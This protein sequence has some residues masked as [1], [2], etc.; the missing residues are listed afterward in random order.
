MQ[1]QSPIRSFRKSLSRSRGTAGFSLV[2]VIMALGVMSFAMMGMLGLLSVGLTNFQ[3]SMDLTVRAQ[4]TQ[5]LTFM[6][7]RTPFT[8]LASSSSLARYYDDEGRILPDLKKTEAVYQA[9]V[10]VG[11]F[12][13]TSGRVSPTWAFSTPPSQFKAVTISI[14]RVGGTG[15]RPYE[16]TTY[17]AN[18]GL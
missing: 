12:A 5:D 3:K 17:V 6:L 18:T 10:Q 11:T 7:Q 15:L 2:E 8:D 16:F 1:H 9:N 14:S 4:I 13:E